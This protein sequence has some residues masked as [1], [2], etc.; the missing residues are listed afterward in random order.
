MKTIVKDGRI[1]TPKGIYVGDIYIVDGIIQ[2]IDKKIRNKEATVIDASERY[3]LPGG[4]DVHTHMEL[5]VGIATSVDT[6]YTGSIAAACGGTTTIIDHVAFG[7]N[8]CNL[9]HQIEAYHGKADGQSVIDYS[10]HGVV[11]SVDEKILKE[12]ESLCKDGIT[13]VKGYLTYDNRLNDADIYQIL[14]QMKKLG[15]ICAFHAENHEIIQYLR[16]KYVK[17]GK[18]APIYHG[19]SRPAEMEAEAIGRLLKIAHLAGDAPL[20][21][22]HLSTEQG[23]WE[24]RKA[25]ERGQKHIFVETCTQYLLLDEEKYQQEDGLKYIMS[26]PLRKVT[27]QDAL[28]KGLLHGEIDV[29]ATDHCPFNYTVEKQQG[30]DDFTKCPNGVPGVEERML[31]LYSE[32]VCKR[33]MTLEQYV[34]VTAANPA[35]VY[36]LYPKKGCLEPGSDA[37]MIILNPDKE[38]ILTQK[39]LHSRVDYTAYEGWQI[40]GSI[41]KVLLRGKVIADHHTWCGTKGQ[42]QFIKRNVTNL[43]R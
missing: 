39:M 42:G 19:K 17:E 34:N 9:H 3:V 16:G 41:E 6:F 40:Q 4:I 14:V 35:K 21:I 25:R 12:M 10:F 8:G 1:V 29:V 11:Q 2:R 22:V 20:Y 27:D 37:D 24:I 28:W 7:P 38:Q 15:G 26:P 32:G 18:L 36:G 43:F 13:S 31:L 5:D 33:R 23:L 30:K